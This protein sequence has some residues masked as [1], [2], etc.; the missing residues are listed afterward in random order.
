MRGV[1][2][3]LQAGGG[4]AA[5]VLGAFEHW[6]DKDGDGE[7]SHFG[8]FDCDD[9]DPTRHTGAVE[10]PGDGIDQD[11]D[12]IDPPAPPRPA[13][14]VD[15]A[16][17]PTRAA[18]MVPVSIRPGARGPDE[19][20]D[21]LLIT[22][23]TVGAGHTSAYG[24]DKPTTPALAELAKR[25][26]LFAHA[27]AT[28]AEPQR[29]LTPI[30]SGRRLQATP[31]DKRTWPTILPETDTLAERLERSGYRT[32]AVTSFTW[33]SNARGFSQGF[34][35]FK[36]VFERAHPERQVTGTFAVEAAEEIIKEHGDDPHPLFLW[37]HLFDAHEVY[38]PHPGLDFGK[39]KVGA[40]DGEV[41]FVDGCVEKLVATLTRARG[42][43]RVA[44]FVHGS[45]GEAFGEHH[46][47]GHG[48]DLFDEVLRVPF[49]A[50]IPGG[51]HGTYE[52]GAVS[53]LDLAPTIAGARRGA[54]ADAARGQVAATDPTRRARR[55]ARPR[56]RAH[57]EARRARRLAAQAH[58][59][60]PR[61]KGE[62]AP[63]RFGRRPARAA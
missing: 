44:V 5:T 52:A 62:S 32:A 46:A 37:V 9:G 30:V 31:H 41:A 48:G 40:Y 25:G 45:H 58:R 38:L 13:D 19:R 24:Y 15:D 33:L 22:L 49:L 23:D 34:R 16:A 59:V 20:P 12:G 2:R 43:A 42:A 8:G 56:V 50:A 17:P 10:I 27:Y 60:G 29:A 61:K 36:P 14:A 3:S 21:V 57:A 4:F 26:V 35:V 55:Q 51:A 1:G 54:A 39:G 28:G 53:T 47:T 11:C 7:G 6:T 18:P 63:L